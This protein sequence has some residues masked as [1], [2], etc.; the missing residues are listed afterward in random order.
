MRK[1]SSAQRENDCQSS[2]GAPSNS[3][4]IGIG[5]GSQMSTAM[6]ARPVAAT[7]SINS[8]TTSRMNGRSR[9]ALRGENAL[10]TRRRRRVWTSPSAARIDG[11]RFEDRRV[12][13]PHHLGDL[14][15]GVVPSLV[16]Q[17]PGDVVVVEDDEAH[18]VPDDPVL[19][20]EGPEV[21]G[22]LGAGQLEHLGAENRKVEIEDTRRRASRVSHG[23]ETTCDG[24][25]R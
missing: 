4:M 18:Q 22:G 8:L 16:A 5:Y 23:D 1:T 11:G 10:A 12:G 15:N 3:Q 21:V 24:E 25:A 2:R 19:R 6:S 17:D 20:S 7:G 9:S 14:R 13:D